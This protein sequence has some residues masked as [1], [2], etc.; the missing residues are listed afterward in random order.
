MPLNSTGLLLHSLLSYQP[1]TIWFSRQKKHYDIMRP[2][3]SCSHHKISQSRESAEFIL[4][5]VQTNTKL[6]LF[7]IDLQKRFCKYFKEDFASKWGT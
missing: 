4:K 1:A 6:F 2:S 7:Y 3:M 5:S